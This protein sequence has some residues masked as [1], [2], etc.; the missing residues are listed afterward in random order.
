MPLVAARLARIRPRRIAIQR[1]GR[2]IAMRRAQ[3][4][5]RCDLE[6]LQ[7]DVRLVETVEEHEAVGALRCRAGGRIVRKFVKNGLSFTAIGIFTCA[8][9]EVRIVR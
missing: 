6:S 2:R 5:V 4:D 7:I 8:L 1:S 9:T 3:Q